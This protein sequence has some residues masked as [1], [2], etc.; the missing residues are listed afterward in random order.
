MSDWRSSRVRSTVSLEPILQFSVGVRSHRHNCPFRSRRHFKNEVFVDQFV[1]LR[2]WS[3]RTAIASTPAM[4][5]SASE[6]GSGTEDAVG[7]KTTSVSR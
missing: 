7:R 5:M 1:R 4:A 6:D 2:R 3:P